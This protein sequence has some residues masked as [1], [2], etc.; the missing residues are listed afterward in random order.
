MHA[1]EMKKIEWL[2]RPCSDSYGLGRSHSRQDFGFIDMI[3][4]ERTKGK[5]LSGENGLAS[6]EM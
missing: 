4:A 6:S 2:G 5:V 1:E 3:S